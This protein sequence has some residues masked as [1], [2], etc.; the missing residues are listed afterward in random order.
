MPDEIQDT[1]EALEAL[2]IWQLLA[3]AIPRGESDR[4]GWMLGVS[5][6][7]VR[8]WRN[9][10]DTDEARPNDAHGR[11]SPFDDFLQFLTAVHARSPKG[12]AMIVDRVKYEFAV[13]Q[14]IHGNQQPLTVRQAA[15]KVREL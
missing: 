10:P 1:T 13:M 12:A 3:K 7:T 9:D 5:G 11:R 14:H 8:S 2:E 6:Q 4:I 15:S